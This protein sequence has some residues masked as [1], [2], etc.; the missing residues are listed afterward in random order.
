MNS[1]GGLDIVPEVGEADITAPGDIA[2]SSVI[3]LVGKE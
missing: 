3:E 1:G 2:K